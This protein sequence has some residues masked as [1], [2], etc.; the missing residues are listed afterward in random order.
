MLKLL[1]GTFY[2]FYFAQVGVYIIFLPKVLYDI[3]YTTTA[4]GIIF[5]VSALMRFAT[6]FFF[7][8]LFHLNDALFIKSLWIFIISMVSAYFTI[9][10]FIPYLITSIL[11]GIALSLVLPYVEAIA[12]DKLDRAVYGKVRLFG[13]IGFMLIAM[14]VARYDLTAD[15]TLHTMMALTVIISTI[16]YILSKHGQVD[17]ITDDTESFSLFKNYRLW[18][19]LFLMQLS[20]GAMYNFFTI[21][22]TDRGIS[23]EQTSYLWSVGVL[24]EILML[25]FQG[26]LLNR[27]SLLSIIKFAT[28]ITAFRWVITSLFASNLIVIYF[29][30]T[31]HAISFALYHS[32][33]IMFLFTIYAQKKLA[34]QFFL[35]IA[36]GLG[37]ALG[38]V[39]AGELYGDYLFLY[40]ALFALVAYLFLI[41]LKI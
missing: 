18:I 31:L 3:E 41:K 30:Q 35:G 11:Y 5:S 37:G 22:E 26:A 6:P 24:A 32:A 17:V 8:K 21:F 39:I 19:S 14:V 27:F 7:L 10:E 1:L 28:L 36:Y 15:L 40:S 4:I 23:L 12:L 34:Q 38:A 2:F 20:F 33:V 13:S 16:S 29:T 25:Y 9:Y